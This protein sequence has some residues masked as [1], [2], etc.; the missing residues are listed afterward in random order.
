MKIIVTGSLGNISKPLTEEL[1]PKGHHVTVLS[2]SPEKQKDI[3]ESG[4]TAAIGSLKDIDFLTATFTGA[5]AAYCMIPPNNY[6][7]PNLDL[8]A[9]YR[10]LGNNYAQTEKQA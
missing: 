5:D 2:S 10:K 8:I 3:G 1:V 7:D 4:A 9:Y 6:F